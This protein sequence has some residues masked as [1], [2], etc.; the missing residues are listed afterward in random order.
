M[1]RTLFLATVVIAF[2]AL[3]APTLAQAPPSATPSGT[4]MNVRGTVDKLD[5]QN[6]TV[7]ARDGQSVT[8]VLA[9][10]FTVRAVVSKSVA[11][12]KAG[13]FV[14]S[15]SIKGPDGTLQ[16]IELHILPANLRGK[17]DGQTPA[18]LV[19]DSLMT[20]ATVAQIVSAPQGQVMKVTY[21]G[22][23]AEINVPPGIPVVGYVSGD[24][25]LLTPGA[26][27]VI[28]ARKLPDGSV[29]ASSVTAEKDGVK[30]PM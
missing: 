8:I 16:A 18:D 25:A 27:V 15:T 11:D 28:F 23:E 1:R 19:P 13:D 9:P 29:T 7:K 24:A 6:L 3:T 30:P 17:I 2:A 26:A 12:I 10:N 4:R 14:A 21:K 5:G 20:N 22:K